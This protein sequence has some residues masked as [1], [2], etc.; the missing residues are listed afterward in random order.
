M[1]RTQLH[2][3]TAAKNLGYSQRIIDMI[4]NAKTD[5]EISRAMTTGRHELEERE[6]QKCI[7]RLQII[8]QQK[9]LHR[10]G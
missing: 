5:N 6:Y 7:K 8:N 1:K 9:R 2:A 10:R 3:I 4:S